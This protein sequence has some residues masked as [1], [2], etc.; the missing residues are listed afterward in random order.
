MAVLTAILSC[1]CFL[2][3]GFVLAVIDEL[4]LT[5]SLANLAF[6]DLF[7]AAITLPRYMIYYVFEASWYK[8]KALGIMTAVF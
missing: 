7:N 5:F 1:A 3:N 6:V 4:F 2:G 8:G